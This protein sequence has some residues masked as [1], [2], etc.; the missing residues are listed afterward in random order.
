MLKRGVLLLLLLV[1]L[2]SPAQ[3]GVCEDWNR[4][5]LRIR[6]F[7]LAPK[8][9]Q[10]AFAPLHQ[11]LR[12][13]YGKAG[14]GG[15]ARFYPV[16]GYDSSGGVEGKAFRP[17]GFQF[18]SGNPQGIHPSLDLFIRDKDQDS[19]DDQSKEPVTIVAYRGGV[20]VGVNRDWEFPSQVR[21]GKYLWIFDPI[22][23]HY[24]YYAHLS[25]VD[26]QLGQII[27]A[28]EPLGLLGRTG[29][30]AYKKRS[31]THLHLMVLAYQDG[32]M[33]PYNP[34]SELVNARLGQRGAEL[35]NQT[36]K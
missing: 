7:Q 28:G 23:N 19:L 31:P 15:P 30:N 32:E 2:A 16:L 3:A 25:Q 10:A 8:E 35:A 11:R 12:A 36:R 21:G 29:L 6:D 27:Q 17:R 26:V 22:T 4:L 9:A 33:M 20:V 1:S 5:W 34:W 24:C 14:I 13:T 18:F